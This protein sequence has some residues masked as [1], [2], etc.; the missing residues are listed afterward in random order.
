MVA[1]G[2]KSVPLAT[3]DEGAKLQ[4][5][6]DGHSMIWS[7][8]SIIELHFTA[9]PSR[10]DEAVAALKAVGGSALSGRSVSDLANLDKCPAVDFAKEQILE[11]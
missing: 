2:A 7:G 3:G 6:A 1:D 8:D 10:T 9:D 4:R 5:F 11:P